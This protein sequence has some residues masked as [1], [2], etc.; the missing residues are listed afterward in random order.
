MKPDGIHHVSINVD[1]VAAA[2]RFYVH[3]LGLSVRPDRP[4]F[5][6]GGAWLDAGGQQVHLIE[7]EPPGDLGQHFALAF[8][9]LAATVARLREL[10]HD[11]TEPVVSGTSLQSFVAD[12][13]GNR[14]EL[15]QPA[16][17]P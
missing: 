13:A 14:V 9:D 3:D 2:L 15:H 16:K 4:N 11:V 6:F 10:G 5:S 12:P 8:S 17:S 1:D 7:G